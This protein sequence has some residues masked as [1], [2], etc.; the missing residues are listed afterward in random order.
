MSLGGGQWLGGALGTLTTVALGSG[1]RCWHA[2]SASVSQ[3]SSIDAVPAWEAGLS[4]ADKAGG[5][6]YGPR[7]Q[8]GAELSDCAIAKGRVCSRPSTRL[9]RG[10]R[11]NF[12][13][14]FPVRAR[15]W[16]WGL[17]LGECG[18]CPA[19][20]Q[21]LCL[22]R[23]RARLFGALLARLHSTQTTVGPGSLTTRHALT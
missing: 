1:R 15:P 21:N 5:W 20:T 3:S 19:A 9:H 4:R 7:I 11:F 12:P 22:C 14:T 18:G 2:L 6:K 10:T 13:G 8:R 23:G 17:R 16:C